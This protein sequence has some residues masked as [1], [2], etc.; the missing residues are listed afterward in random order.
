MR[1][2]LACLSAA[3]LSVTL[4]DACSDRTPAAP[5]APREHP[6]AQDGTTARAYT[7]AP[8]RA[9]I[10][11]DLANARA[12]IQAYRGE[13]GALPP[14]LGALRLEGV[15]YPKDLQYDPASGTVRSETYP[16]Y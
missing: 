6:L 12:A 13:H 8:D 4:L 14:D 9:K 5:A 15:N 3:A 1:R 16:S 10:Q 11:L 2:L 7:S